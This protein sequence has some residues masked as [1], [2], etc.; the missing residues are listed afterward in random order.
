MIRAD[1]AI[2]AEIVQARRSQKEGEL[3]INQRSLDSM[4]D[5]DTANTAKLKSLVQACGWPLI[6]KYGAQA[7]SDAFLVVQH[8]SHDRDFQRASL[9]MIEKAADAGEARLMDVAYLSDRLAVADGRPQRYGTQLHLASRCQLELKPID[10]WAAVN[11][12]R[13]KADLPSLEEYLEMARSR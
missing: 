13:E 2:R 11:A 6:S 3:G 4:R 9:E 7:S 8:A 1:Q 10:D 5:I 12:R